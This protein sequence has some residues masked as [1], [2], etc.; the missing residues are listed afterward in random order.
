MIGF[1]VSALI[2]LALFGAAPALGD[3]L[4]L[5]P[6]RG[7]WRAEDQRIASGQIHAPTVVE[8]DDGDDE[9]GDDDRDDDGDDAANGWRFLFAALTGD[10]RQA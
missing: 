2:N 8:E 4:S 1:A 6:D 3:P 5:A 9:E 7:I 10:A